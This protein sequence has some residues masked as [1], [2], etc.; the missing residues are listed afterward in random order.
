MSADPY[1]PP[2]TEQLQKTVP[3]AIQADRQAH[4][5][6]ERDLATTGTIS[7]IFGG[8]TSLLTLLQV[9]ESTS[10]YQNIFHVPPILAKL[11]VVMVMTLITAL[12]IWIGIGLHRRQPA[13][14]IPA[15]L[16]SALWMLVFPLGTA[17]GG[18]T[19]WRL[20]SARGKRVYAPDYAAVVEATPAVSAKLPRVRLWVVATTMV[21]GTLFLLL[22]AML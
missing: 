17:V 18:W 8:L 19:L 14:R 2:Q 4:I 21:L 13:G 15:S 7:F 16:V 12:H 6:T 10:A 1:R 9:L 3:A 20:W 5:H 22:L 11:F